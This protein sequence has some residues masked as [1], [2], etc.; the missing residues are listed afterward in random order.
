[1]FKM[2]TNNVPSADFK[3]LENSAV[4]EHTSYTHEGSV[5]ACDRATLCE[6]V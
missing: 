4:L 1:M 5:L 3:I 2:Y 6:H